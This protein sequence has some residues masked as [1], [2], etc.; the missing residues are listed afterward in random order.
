MAYCPICGAPI[1]EQDNFCPSCGAQLTQEEIVVE[2]KKIIQKRRIG[3][4]VWNVIITIV[5]VLVLFLIWYLSK[6]S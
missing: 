3:S 6:V 2:R 4:I 5:A 1:S